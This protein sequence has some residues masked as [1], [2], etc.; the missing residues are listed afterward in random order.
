[1]TI[2]LRLA[3]AALATSL[4]PTLAAGACLDEA[5]SLSERL[6]TPAAESR[7]SADATPQ[8]LGTE[9]EAGLALTGDP[10]NPYPP[11][12]ATAEAP[13]ATPAGEE[14]TAAMPGAD[15]SVE[16][17]GEEGRVEVAARVEEA[18]AAAEAGD[19]E[20]C[21]AALERVRAAMPTPSE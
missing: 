6:D 19:E 5:R 1:M 4:L 9:P 18:M 20:A 8:A 3:L 11:E 21:L 7:P 16:L 13:L 17:V 14:A 10:V 15:P 2:R 12:P